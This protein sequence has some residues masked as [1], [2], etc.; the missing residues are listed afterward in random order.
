M[1]DQP[2]HSEQKL[3]RMRRRFIFGYIWVALFL[4]TWLAGMFHVLTG[5]ALGK[6]M[7]E[8]PSEAY[9]VT[10]ETHGHVYFVSNRMIQHQKVTRFI[11]VVLLFATVLYPFVIIAGISIWKH[12]FSKRSPEENA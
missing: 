8:V 2:N 1:H 12:L 6:T 7:F 3:A 11:A 9:S 5:P 4:C 10:Y